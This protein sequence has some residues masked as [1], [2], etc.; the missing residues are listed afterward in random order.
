M[1]SL[2][3]D[4]FQITEYRP[5]RI[6]RRGEFVAWATGILVAGA[7]LTLLLLHSE[8]PFA[9]PILA[10]LLLLS[11]MAI[12]LG[13]WMDRRSLIRLEPEEIRFE[14]GL[15]QVRVHY[16]EIPQLEVYPSEWGSKVRVWSPH[17]HFDFR[18]LGEVKLKGE[19]KGRL[20]YL[21]GEK[22]LNHILEKADLKAVENCDSG[23]YYVRN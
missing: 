5:E 19:I 8:V 4:S 23:Y 20:G 11:G 18:T 12:S 13:N 14:N 15:R 21:D 17:G 6:S 9:V 7:W 22:I 1:P 10:V 3:P 16:D 2:E